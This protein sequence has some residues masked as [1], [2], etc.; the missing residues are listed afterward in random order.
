MADDDVADEESVV[1]GL[2]EDHLVEEWLTHSNSLPLSILIGGRTGAGKST[3][4]NH[5]LA[6]TEEEKCEEGSGSQSETIHVRKVTKSIVGVTL[7]IFDT[8]GLSDRRREL[9][10]SGGTSSD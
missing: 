7:E 6:L 10:S 3:F 5:F 9:C 1:E 8:P 2:D 4:I